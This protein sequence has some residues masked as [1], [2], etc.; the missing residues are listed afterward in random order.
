MPDPCDV[1]R[2]AFFKLYRS[3][4]ETQVQGNDPHLR[5]DFRA[6]EILKPLKCNIVL[7][8]LDLNVI[9]QSNHILADSL[10]EI[11]QR[12]VGSCEPIVNS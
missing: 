12:G 7:E 11:A 5:I 6:G 9:T 10:E 1:A 2:E 3:R 4:I 8:F